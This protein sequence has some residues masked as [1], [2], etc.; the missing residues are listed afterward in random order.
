MTMAAVVTFG[1]DLALLLDR[2]FGAA[3]VGDRWETTSAEVITE[4]ASDV[5]THLRGHGIEAEDITE[6]HAPRSYR[7][8]QTTILYGAASELARRVGATELEA[9]EA[10][11]QKFKDRLAQLDSNANLV[12]GD[13]T[14]RARSTRTLYA[15]R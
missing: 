6:A 14:T 1:V 4:V 9:I 3:E 12:L 5:E 13:L 2:F 10:W 15:F 8:L 7:W 11:D